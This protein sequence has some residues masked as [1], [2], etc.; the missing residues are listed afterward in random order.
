MYHGLKSHIRL[1]I[2]INLYPTPNFKLYKLGKVM[3][4]ELPHINS[5]Y[6]NKKIHG[7]HMES[8]KENIFFPDCF[9]DVISEK[10]ISHINK[11]FE[12]IASMIFE[13]YK[14]FAKPYPE[15]KTAFE[16]FA[17]DT[18]IDTDMNVHLIEVNDK[19][20]YGTSNGIIDDIFIKFSYDYFDWIFKY[21]I[22]PL[23][24]RIDDIGKL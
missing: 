12:E 14:H 19:V 20:G 23:A 13:I 15:S 17:I 4:A 5:D 6:H 8:T 3:T 1:Y 22:K 16:I 11:Q 9:S 7:S 18:I 21:A 10:Q 2:L 24:T